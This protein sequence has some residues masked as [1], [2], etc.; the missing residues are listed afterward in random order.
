M[1]KSTVI[2]VPNVPFTSQNYC[3]FNENASCH[4]IVLLYV[5]TYFR[6]ML[7]DIYK[8]DIEMFGTWFA[9]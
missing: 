3:L 7:R 9:R 8:E 1:Q 5:G 2:T 4:R 6:P